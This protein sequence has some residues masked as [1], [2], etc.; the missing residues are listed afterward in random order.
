MN[1]PTFTDRYPTDVGSQHIELPLVPLSDQLTIAL[2]I[3]VDVPLSFIEQAGQELAERLRPHGPEVVATA[4]TLGI[5]IAWATA[6]AL[7]HDELVVL[8][9][10]PKTHLADALVEPL[11]SIT[12]K[13]EQVFRL[14]RMQAPRVQ[15]RA[16]AFVDDV[17]STGGSAAAAVRLLERAGGRIAAVGTMLT[18]GSGWKEALTEHVGRIET[19]GTIPVFTPVDGGW[20]PASD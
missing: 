15:G 9:K 20:T 1:Q 6:R 7:G 10:T 4:A 17:I 18:E 8:H 2:L 16:V 5:P 14:D 11:S 19:L 12:T 13:G 3:T